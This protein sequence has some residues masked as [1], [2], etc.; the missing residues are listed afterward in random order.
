MT[1]RNGVCALI[2]IL[3]MAGLA[4]AI[5]A[6]RAAGRAVYLVALTD[7]PLAAQA[8][9]RVRSPGLGA[10][11]ERRMVRQELQ[12]D[13]SR[14]YLR[15]LDAARA[16]VVDLAQQRIGRA[17][18]PRQVYRYASNGLALELDAGEAARV[19]SLPGVAAV[20]R[21]R[22]LHLST[23][24]GPQWI[25]ANQLWSGVGGIAPT[26]GEGVVIG[27]IDT[28]INPTHPSFAAASGDGYT[29]SNPRG[30][31]YGL[32]ASG[33][34]QCNAKLIGIYDF[35]TEGS[36]GIDTVG[37]G[38]HVSGIA[39]GDAIADA[40]QGHTVSLPRNV[41]GVAPHAN[42]IMYK[43]CNAQ[44]IDAS[45]DGTC[46]ESAL[47]AAIDQATAD[48]VD[49]INYSIGGGT[50]DP[51]A[52]LGDPTTDAT[53]FFHAREAGI[54]ISVSAG[55]DGPGANTLDEPGNV[56]WV[57][58]VANASHNR[59]FV[60]SLGNLT[61][62]ANAPATL[63]G[64]GYTA[65]YGPANIVY[66]GNYGNALCGVG[67]TEGVTPTGA[68]NPFAA[69]TFH[70]EIVICDR[71]IYARVE[72][73]YNVK[74][75]GAG[76]YILANAASDGESI[77]SDDHFLPAVHLG[78]SEGQALE[79][80]VAAAGTHSGKIAGV[81]A[82]LDAAFGDI[83]D[84]SS[85][86]GP[87]GFGGGVLKPDLTAPGDNILS[88]AQTGNGLALLSGTSMASPHVAG[89]AA[90]VLSVHPDW[91]PAQVESALIGT[92]LAGSVRMQDGVSSASPLD[93]GT[94]RVQ[95]ALAAQAGLYLPLAGIDFLAGSGTLANPSQHGDLVK[96]NR[97]GIESENCFAHCSFSRSV[98]D[99]SNGGTW[100]VTATATTGAQ[101]KVTP[102]QFTLAAGGSQ[103]LAI[104]L[105][106]SDPRLPGNWVSGRIV[107]HKT[108]GGR[109]ATDT[110]LTI[111]AYATPGA[112]QA[113]R[114]FT[115]DSAG[116]YVD[117]PVS[118]LVEL[119]NA[120]FATTTL[121][122]AN[123]T[124]M[125]LGVDTSSS[126]QVYNPGTGKQFVLFPMQAAGNA[127]GF[128]AAVG[129][130]FIVEITAS[131]A[132]QAVLY[133][134]IDSNNDGAPEASEQACKTS[135]ST[136]QPVARCVVDLHDAPAG[137][138]SVWALVDV[139]QGSPGASYS[140][141]LSGAV[142]MIPAGTTS[143]AVFNNAP[144]VMTGPG[145]VDASS[146]F[147][148][149]MAWG[150]ATVGTQSLI[151]PGNYYGAIL[152]DAEPGSQQG[153]AG[154]VPFSFTRSSGG[155]DVA[156]ALQSGASRVLHY[157]PPQTSLQHMFID[158]PA[159][160]TSLEVD[161]SLLIGGDAQVSFA[162]VR[163]DF[164]PAS[165]PAQIAAAPATTPAATWALDAVTQSRKVVIPVTPGRWY[166]V[167]SY[168]SSR[169][170]ASAQLSAQLAFG[171]A[172]APALTPGNYFNPQRSGHG[173][174]LSRAAGQ[175]VVDWY[176]FRE[177]GT[178]TWYLAQATAP[179][180][181]AG[182]WS[183]D[184]YR[185]SWN[186]SSGVPTRVGEVALTATAPDRAMFSWHLDGTSGSEAFQL[187]ASPACVSDGGNVNLNGEWFPPAQAGYGFD[188]LVLPGQQFDA[189]YMY[190]GG[191]NPRWVVGANGPFAAS[192]TI[193]ML[194]S[195]GFCPVC[196]YQALT[197][198]AA[199]N[200]TVTY[201]N[202]AGGQLSTAITL[203]APLNG[204][205]SIN[206]PIARLTGSSDCNP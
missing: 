156:D 34:A 60:N 201:A 23:D 17:L 196:A 124:Q 148:V 135:Y 198:Q 121:A 139:P 167:S 20:R 74:A 151:A 159:G 169:A 149:R 48:Q 113:F 150:G 202:G 47:V 129:R 13:A 187:I 62:A 115:A 195:T 96:L 193:A 22:A 182:A 49:V 130:V 69:G 7:P 36:K 157:S 91:S 205:W 127:G 39:A 114:Q 108:G 116:G 35:T 109:S 64:Q 33:Q 29:I 98:T 4:G 103:T 152:I 141:T 117:V 12:S 56:P 188:A 106:V 164:P 118:G 161:T 185:A 102:S 26:K 84:A 89:S 85:S 21:E 52:L 66:A 112:T 40:L 2:A 131:S 200:M 176:T 107:L 53:A 199:G 138:G 10:Q 30:H 94:G 51:Y 183:A 95:P 158:V 133:A 5:A 77:I 65:G 50:M 42:L 76:G 140:V 126:D 93:A 173:I 120:A 123:V 43:G 110:A 83:L 146:S 15:R 147:P 97:A 72:K 206:Q 32:C 16:G 28:G 86:R 125:S 55:N 8:A 45:S 154:Y 38:S 54:V 44:P 122:P 178:P 168:A 101:L 111:A 119:P 92:A 3:L 90:L 137:T 163:A 172:A 171:A 27:V 81:S 71:G 204:S 41:S 194:Q 192:S 67:A 9:A 58:G 82:V 87:Y 160:A 174:F 145:H 179:A 1:R 59:R 136:V 181:T 19:A 100:Q 162:A 79:A 14:A 104:A 105:D 166:L 63:T 144:F 165:V 142:P 191:G 153:L 73:G 61:G 37:H 57:I 46:A 88:A 99:M 75:A 134:G 6:E 24:A 25:G 143:T 186:G 190:D 132:V 155:D 31:F 18:T 189:F 203:N 68:S 78:Y 175:Q 170:D 184:L 11:Q 197:T 128:P 180:N 80:W 177:D 70:G